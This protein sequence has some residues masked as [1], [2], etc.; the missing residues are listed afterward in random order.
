MIATLQAVHDADPE[1]QFAEGTPFRRRQLPL[2]GAA[3]EV[4]CRE[5]GVVEHVG[6]VAPLLGCDERV[7][8]PLPHFP[9]DL[10]PPPRIA[11]VVAHPIPQLEQPLHPRQRLHRLG[12]PGRGGQGPTTELHFEH[13]PLAIA[14]LELL[15]QRLAAG[16]PLGD[17]TALLLPGALG[18]RQ[19]GA[20]M[21]V[22]QHLAGGG[23]HGGRA[24]REQR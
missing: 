13:H 9:V 20:E 21:G 24:L 18:D 2:F 14:P 15:H 11:D 17:D 3:F 12:G 4:G 8:E 23:L 7:A 5:R 16:D 1:E 22:E 6:G 10:S 19:G